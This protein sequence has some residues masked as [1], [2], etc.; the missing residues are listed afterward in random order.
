ML[1][2]IDD[3]NRP[4][5]YRLDRTDECYFIGEYTAGRGYLHSATNQLIL[6]LKKSVDRR[7]LPEWGYKERDILRAAATLR[8]S[9]NPEFLAVAT[10]VPVPPS[11]IVGDPLYDDRMT[12]VLRALG[13]A[14]DVRELVRQIE[15]MQDAHSAEHR[16]GPDALYENYYIDTAVAEPAPTVIAIVDDVLTTGAHFKAMYRILA[17][18]LAVPII[19]IFLARRVPHTE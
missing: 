2:K 3:L 11:R 9:L 7:G 8:A 15:T 12:Q 18:T 14:A 5:H 10:F 19:G 4:D 6:N 17:E 16:P 13:P 1:T